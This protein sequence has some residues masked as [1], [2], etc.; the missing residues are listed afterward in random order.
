ME[1][2]LEANVGNGIAKSRYNKL[3]RLFVVAN[4]Y[5]KGYIYGHPL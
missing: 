3:S 4:Y 2:A 1:E 5:E